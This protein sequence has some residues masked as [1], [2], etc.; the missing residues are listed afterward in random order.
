[1]EG[2]FASKQVGREIAVTYVVRATREAG[3]FYGVLMGE[4]NT[5]YAHLRSHIY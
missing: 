3:V 2:Y 4:H 5:P 1:V